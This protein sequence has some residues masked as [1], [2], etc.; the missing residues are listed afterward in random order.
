[1]TDLS[2]R[3]FLKSA[4]AATLVALPSCAGV[5]GGS[6]AKPVR[7]AIA[8]V[9]VQGRQHLL[10]FQ[11]NP[12]ARVVAMADPDAAQLMQAGAAVSRDG[13][14]PL[15]T[16]NPLELLDHRGID[17][18][19][20]ATPDH[21]HA[22]LAIR[23]CEAG[24]HVFVENPVSHSIEEGAAM[25]AAA[26]ANGR[27]VQSGLVARAHPAVRDAVRYVHSGAFGP[28]RAIRAICYL[29][30][31]SIGRAGG[32]SQL[33]AHVDF[34]VWTGPA[35]KSRLMR[36]RLHGD[37][38]FDW[39]TGNGELGEAGTELLDLARW[40]LGKAQHSGAHDSWPDRIWTCGGRLGVR[41]DGETPNTLVA[42]LDF[43]GVPVIFDQRG[44]PTRYGEGATMDRYR[45]VQYGLVVE[46]EERMLAIHPTRA[47]G[48]V[49]D[50]DGNLERQF[51]GEGSVLADFI[52]AIQQRRELSA[53]IE[54]GRT[55][56]DLA[57]LVNLA[58]RTGRL[59]TRV[60]ILRSTIE[61][62]WLA[63][64][65]DGMDSHLA[66]NGL[67][68]DHE[69]PVLSG[70]QAVDRVTGELPGNDAA[71]AL[72]RRDHRAPFTWKPASAGGKSRFG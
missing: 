3:R 60:E 23:A 40:I 71:N 6:R 12:D 16:Q 67:D 59:A 52:A 47:V 65:F 39:R 4:T 5:S 54:I 20:I 24:K 29:H 13:T 51:R 42:V 21:W 11:R 8:G 7:V 37:W 45:G 35:P 25:V 1:M 72:R 49:Y 32:P 41:D 44:L 9:R 63:A 43:D 50:Q 48:V 26:R 68:L 27:L 17:A 2:R 22:L 70:W 31:P 46:G 69:Q 61:D 66:R 64:Y 56:A 15:I 36:R 38:R 30:R 34:D 33:P 53:D 62:P 18:I 57:H 19:S 14:S 10:E 28:I 55:A 58:H